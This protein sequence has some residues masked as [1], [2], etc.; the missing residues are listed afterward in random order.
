MSK[1]ILFFVPENQTWIQKNFQNRLLPEI[2]KDIQIHSYERIDKLRVIEPSACIFTGLGVITELERE[3]SNSLWDQLENHGFPIRLMNH[4]KNTL[5]RHAL[6]K[7]LFRLNINDFRSFYL[8]EIP[9]TNLN[10][11]IFIREADKHTGSLSEL[12]FSE[13]ELEKQLQNLKKSGY[14]LNSLLIVEYIRTA[15]QNNVFKKYSAFKIGD[16]II[17]RYL[18]LSHNWVAKE[19]AE[20]PADKTLYDDDHIKEEFDYITAN[21]HK[22]EL[23]NI[24]KIAGIDY[25]RIDYGFKDGKLQVWEINTL[26]TFGPSPKKKGPNPEELQL[27]KQKRGPSKSYFYSQLNSA[28]NQLIRVESAKPVVLKLE[29]KLLTQLK[30]ERFRKQVAGFSLKAGAMLPRISHVQKLRS[31]IRRRLIETGK[32]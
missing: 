28:M 3:L 29:P 12:I 9:N 26:P 15:D 6:H 4:P 14:E 21:P 18:T 23:F 20:S 10:Y 16:T 17:P 8:H 7:E 13:F 22:D 30:K 2:A 11:P 25:G 1:K 5:N 31:Y 32:V 24:F 19:N 27:R